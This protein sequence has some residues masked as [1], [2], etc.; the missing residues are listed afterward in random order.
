MRG[1]DPELRRLLRLVATRRLTGI[2]D[3]EL[4][5]AIEET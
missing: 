2:G 3:T 5:T 4:I 1:S